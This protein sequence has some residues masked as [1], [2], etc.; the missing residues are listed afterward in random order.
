MWDALL[1]KG[2]KYQ[3]KPC[4]LGARDTLRVEMRYPLYGHELSD[5]ISP[6][7]ADLEWVVK[8]NK[9]DF[10]G[11]PALVQQKEKGL[12]SMKLKSVDYFR[13]TLIAALTFGLI[14]DP[15]PQKSKKK[16]E[17]HPLLNY[18]T[19]PTGFVSR[20]DGYSHIRSSIKAKR[21]T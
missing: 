9:E 17:V 18:L 21:R 10:I 19:E 2:K 8:W 4:G 5:K 6:L 15:A 1:E 16:K 11:K 3:I 13:P 14:S 20:T 12:K 7:E